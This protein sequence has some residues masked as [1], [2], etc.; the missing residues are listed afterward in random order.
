MFDLFEL[1]RSF[2]DYFNNEIVPFFFE[3]PELLE[4]EYFNSFTLSMDSITIDY[5]FSMPLGMVILFEGFV[6]VVLFRI[7]FGFIFAVVRMITNLF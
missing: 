2:S 1:F 3:M 4:I 6:F 7:I 5:P